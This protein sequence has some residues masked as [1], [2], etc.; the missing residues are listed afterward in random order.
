MLNPG[1][2]ILIHTG[3]AIG[4]V[5]PIGL[6]TVEKLMDKL[7]TLVPELNDYVNG[8]I[9]NLTIDPPELIRTLNSDAFTDQMLTS[10]TIDMDEISLFSNALLDGRISGTKLLTYAETAR[11]NRLA[12]QEAEDFDMRSGTDLEFSKH[13]SLPSPVPGR[14]QLSFPKR[15]Y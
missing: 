14:R 12:K 7:I 15:N 9:N 6:D 11:T 10:G 13:I 8:S 5:G 1:Q 4:P 2:F 3:I